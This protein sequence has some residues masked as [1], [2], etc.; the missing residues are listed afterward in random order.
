MALE[1]RGTGPPVALVGKGTGPP[2]ALVGRVTG[3]PV[4]W[5]RWLARVGEA[6]AGGVQADSHCADRLSGPGAGRAALPRTRVSAPHVSPLP[7]RVLTRRTAA[8]VPAPGF[9]QTP[10]QPA[11]QGACRQGTG[12]G[13]S[14]PRAAASAGAAGAGAAGAGTWRALCSGTPGAPSPA[15]LP[16]RRGAR[17]NLDSFPGVSGSLTFCSVP[18]TH[19]GSF[20]E[21]GGTRG[22]GGGEGC[23]PVTFDGTFPARVPPTPRVRGW[24]CVRSSDGLSFGLS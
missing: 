2:V 6:E 3:I 22:S 13:T 21:D 15:E 1:G 17:V 7:T 4:A 11:G 12:G 14:S 9:H 19:T 10:R 24:G 18:L 8:H 20:G 16:P 5:E 23:E